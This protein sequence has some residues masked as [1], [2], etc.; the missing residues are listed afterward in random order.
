MVTRSHDQNSLV[1]GQWNAVCDRCGF[2]FKSGDLRK[3][4]TGNMVCRDCFEVRH[5]QDFVKGVPDNQNV[6]WTRPETESYSAIE[7]IPSEDDGSPGRQY[8][9]RKRQGQTVEDT[10]IVLSMDTDP[11]S[12]ELQIFSTELTTDRTI[13]IDTTSAVDGDSFTIYV[14]V[15][16]DYSLDIGGLQTT[17]VPSITVVQFDGTAWV[18]ISYTTTGL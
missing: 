5:P 17:Y 2:K 9:R 14:T 4:W 6:A 3:E 10:D 13:I 18:L 11:P 15:T 12:D 1:V 7:A 16:S 8:Q